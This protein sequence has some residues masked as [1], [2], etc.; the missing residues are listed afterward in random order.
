MNM[1]LA[2]SVRNSSFIIR[3]F[4]PCLLGQPLRRLS[5]LA[6]FTLLAGCTSPQ[7]SDTSNSIKSELQSRT[8]ARIHAR[9]TARSTPDSKPS[10]D[11]PRL[12]GT[13]NIED[14][15]KLAMANNRALRIAYLTRKDA[16]GLVMQKYAG[17]MPD[18]TAR[19]SAQTTL[20]QDAN[21]DTYLVG[22][23]I[24]Q[25]L[26]R[27][28]S[29]AAGLRYAKLYSASTDFTIREAVQS[30]VFDI[31]SKYMDVLLQQHLVQVDEEATGVSQR[32][33]QTAKSRRQ[34][35]V[36]SDYEVLRAEVE[37]ANTSAGLINRKNALQSAKVA[38]FQAMG[39]SQDSDVAFD[40]ELIY[41]AEAFD[42][43]AA[44]AKASVERPT[45]A[46]ALA[47]LRMADE[48]INI[49]K[50]E[51]G[52]SVDGFLTGDYSNTR[53]FK[54]DKSSSEWDDDWTVGA[55]VTLT[56]FDGFERR[57]KVLSAISKREQAAESLRDIEDKVH[58]EIVNALL[59]LNYSDELYQS[60]KKNI[61][62]SREAL[63]ILEV[64]SSRGRN[65]Q[66]EVLDARSALTE[67]V[68]AY[69]RS[70]HS[71]GLARLAIRNAMGILSPDD[72]MDTIVK[73]LTDTDTPEATP[74]N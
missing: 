15:I 21:S 33:L 38:L 68:G 49:V 53:K 26:W 2:V 55:R 35:G 73:P 30:T 5:L 7:S 51:Y 23:G 6:V 56:L 66:V 64:G 42:L 22:V 39:V 58:V 14:A 48:Q 8:D 1:R 40:G 57:G 54:D 25:P 45:I 31:A 17:V 62:L 60:Q 34:Q 72:S 63:R 11:L 52:P 16:D 28:G 59:Q 10:D 12:A 32:V 46:R 13:L 71:Q 50:A 36:V 67:A 37:V 20:P 47:A 70:I 19:A 4:S 9:N 24:I 65:T 27:S 29:V 18:I 69:Y 43:E 74:E 44:S 41:A 3:N 61:E